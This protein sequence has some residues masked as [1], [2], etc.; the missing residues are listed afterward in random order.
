MDSFPTSQL[1]IL[2]CLLYKTAALARSWEFSSCLSLLLLPPFTPLLT[3]SLSILRANL[4]G[5]TFS[6][7]PVVVPDLD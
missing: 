5:S 2:I 4:F 3:S 1:P 7:F 6:N